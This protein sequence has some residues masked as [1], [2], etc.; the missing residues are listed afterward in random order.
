MSREGESFAESQKSGLFDGFCDKMCDTEALS[1][2]PVSV[3]I[4]IRTVHFPLKFSALSCRDQHVV[5]TFILEGG[6]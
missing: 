4:A 6:L 1:S 3:V 5:S 2:G